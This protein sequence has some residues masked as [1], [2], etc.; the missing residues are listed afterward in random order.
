MLQIPNDEECDRCIRCGMD[1]YYDSEIEEE[2]DWCYECMHREEWEAEQDDK[3]D[4]KQ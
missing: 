2:I 1:Y 3:R 4:R